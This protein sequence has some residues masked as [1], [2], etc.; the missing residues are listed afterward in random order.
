MHRIDV[1][2]EMLLQEPHDSFL[3]YALAIELEKENRIA[4]AITTIEKIIARDEQ[5]LGAYYKLGKL[6]EASGGRSKA[7]A[8]YEKGILIA[9]QQKNNKTLNELNEALQ[10]L[11]D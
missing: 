10:Q 2:K 1:I 6:H 3:N 7:A 9:R 4:E 5:Y 11:E 8:V